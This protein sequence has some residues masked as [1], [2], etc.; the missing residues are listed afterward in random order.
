M[1]ILNMPS[2]FH[3]GLS[4]SVHRGKNKVSQNVVQNDT[5]EKVSQ[6]VVQND[7]NES[8]AKILVRN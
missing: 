8:E 6:N 4:N 2:S 1:F 3:L 7:M 5:N